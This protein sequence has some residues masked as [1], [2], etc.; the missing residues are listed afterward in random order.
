MAV[1]ALAPA[2]AAMV[3]EV[4]TYGGEFSVDEGLWQEVGETN[5]ING[6]AEGVQVREAHAR[7]EAG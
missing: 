4:T 1:F 2:Q 7:L 6:P 3:S 5:T